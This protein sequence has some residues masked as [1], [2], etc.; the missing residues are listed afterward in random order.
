MPEIDW[1]NAALVE[2]NS[3]L[4]NIEATIRNA[5]GNPLLEP[6]LPSLY[7]AKQAIEGQKENIKS[8]LPETQKL[9]HNL[10]LYLQTPADVLHLLQ[11]D[12]DGINVRSRFKQLRESFQF[13]VDYNENYLSLSDPGRKYK[14]LDAIASSDLPQGSSASIDDT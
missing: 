7:A 5:P 2:A 6:S 11:N 4:K 13:I 14:A 3:K 1:A 9:T 12:F 8:A 10:Y